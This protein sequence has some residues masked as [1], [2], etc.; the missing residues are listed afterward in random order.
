MWW[1]PLLGFFVIYLVCF[2]LLK[3]LTRGGKKRQDEILTSHGHRPLVFGAITQALAGVLPCG[4]ATRQR[5]SRF[6]PHAGYYHRLALTEFLALRNILVVGWALLTVAVIVVV[7]EPGEPLMYE[8]AGGGLMAALLL[9]SLPRLGL[10]I[11]AKRRVRRIGEALPDALDMI[12]MCMSG[13]L[14]LQYA[15]SRVSDEMQSIHPD[16][17]FE[18]RIVGR[19]M[20]AGS[21]DS[22]ITQFARRIDAP[23]VHS[24]AAMICQ[25]EQQGGNVASAFETFA[26][27]VRL[28]RRQRAEEVGNKTAIKLLFPLVFCLAPPVYLM[29]L[30]PAAIEVRDVVLR[31]NQPGGALAASKIDIRA[32]Q[33]STSAIPAP[34]FEVGT[35]MSRNGNGNGNGNGARP[36]PP[37]PAA[38]GSTN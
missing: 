15:M 24:L 17:A 11:A 32:L 9:Y 2:G 12:T 29:L 35:E 4:A 27:S 18:L 31:E 19:Q 10:E 6:L 16:L 38:P 8:I 7:T 33:Q 30:A 23:E 26:D 37:A 28:N 36:T 1:Y 25:T 20:E 3:L 21:L 13:G 14:P 34:S 5:L 22:A